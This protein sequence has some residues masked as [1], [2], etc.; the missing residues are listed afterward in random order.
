MCLCL[1][2]VR[3]VVVGYRTKEEGVCCL[4]ERKCN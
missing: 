1:C 3:R 4:N 2:S